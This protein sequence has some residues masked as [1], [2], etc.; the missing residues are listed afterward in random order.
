MLY[1]EIQIMN[2]Y[3]MNLGGGDPALQTKLR[4]EYLEKVRAEQDK[5][6]LSGQPIQTNWNPFP[7]WVE[8]L[9][10]EMAAENSSMARFD[11][12]NRVYR[13]RLKGT[14]REFEKFY[15]DWAAR[16]EV[17]RVADPKNIEWSSENVVR[18]TCSAENENDALYELDA[19]HSGYPSTQTRGNRPRVDSAEEAARAQA[20]QA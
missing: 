8:N 10:E 9:I 11:D 18:V 19:H 13:L 4:S 15:Q 14:R 12:E 5:I 17:A 1:V 6:A 20:A 16:F 7:A 3:L 2:T